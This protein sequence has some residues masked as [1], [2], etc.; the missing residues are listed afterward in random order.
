MS[1]NRFPWRSGP[2]QMLYAGA[3]EKSDFLI[4]IKE[5]QF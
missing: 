3:P 5:K 1:A 4:Q 2:A